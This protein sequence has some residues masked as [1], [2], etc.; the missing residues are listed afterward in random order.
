MSTSV[1]VLLADDEPEV[2]R[3]LR[4][5]LRK[6]PWD[7]VTAA[8][9]EE[10]LERLSESSFDVVV[11]DER[12]PGMQGS[13]LLSH[14]R[15]EH[16][17]T[18]RI[19]LSGQASVGAAVKAINAAEVYRFLLKPCPCEEVVLTIREALDKRTRR[20]NFEAW[21]NRLGDDQ[22]RASL[23]RALGSLWIGFQPI[24]ESRG[25]GVYGYEALVRSGDQM[26]HP[27]ALF[28]AAESLGRSLELGARIRDAVA[29]RI[30][31]APRGANIFVN[32][33]PDDL[34]NKNL[35]SSDS[36]LAAH[37]ERVVLE[38]TE[39]ESL[40]SDQQ[41]LKQTGR[42]RSLGY[43]IAVDDL[44]SGF[45]GLNSVALLTPEFIKLD[46]ELIRNIDR[47]LTKRR[48]VG[49]M[50]TMCLD[51]NITSVAEGIESVGERD[52][53]V[54]LGCCLLQ[55]FFYGKA[56]RTFARARRLAPS[57]CSPSGAAS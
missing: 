47:S 54:D 22:L 10:A 9:A 13:D 15:A 32:V 34:G 42:L 48:L 2:T 52:A 24:V 4:R 37:A 44:G 56:E 57:L 33:N 46:M 31:D 1:R 40:E 27:R 8:S 17:S 28:A 6:E 29:T 23:D 20:K 36:P 50:S 30:R 11:S 3:S 38:I 18:I 14:V 55:G 35:Y 19:I 53:V 45:S 7:V 12:M 26:G 49:A 51:F 39:R 5:G 16:P 41:L 21:R 25:E 43:R